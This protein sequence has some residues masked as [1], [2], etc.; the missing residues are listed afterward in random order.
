[1]D[2]GTSPRLVPRPRRPPRSRAEAQVSRDQTGAAVAPRVRRGIRSR[3]NCTRDG[4]R[5]R[6]VQPLRPPER[7]CWRLGPPFGG[8]GAATHQCQGPTQHLAGDISPPFRLEWPHQASHTPPTSKKQM[9]IGDLE[10]RI[11]APRRSWNWRHDCA[12]K[13]RGRSGRSPSGCTWAVG[14]VPPPGSTA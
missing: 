1:V 2:C 13:R 14:R 9:P 3:V 6:R 5:H 10:K 4:R 11:E 7:P 12:G 8:C